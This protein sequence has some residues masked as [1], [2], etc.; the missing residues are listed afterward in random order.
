MGAVIRMHYLEG[1]THLEIAEALELA[2]GT[3]KSRLAYGVTKLRLEFG[4][5]ESSSLRG[6]QSQAPKA[7][8]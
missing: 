4:K 5:R 8:P 1:L 6:P 2:L 3:V 7:A